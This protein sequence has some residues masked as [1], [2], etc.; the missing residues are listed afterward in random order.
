ME[1]NPLSNKK[2]Q[3]FLA[4]GSNLGD[5]Q[6]ALHQAVEL[7]GQRVGTVIQK[8]SIIETPAWGL[9]NLPDY[10]N[11]VLKVNTSLWPL[12]L[13]KTTLEIENELGRE[14]IQ[15][16][17]SRIIDIDILYFNDWHFTTPGLIIPHPFIAQ[18]EFVLKPLCEIAPEFSHPI[19][20][21]SN[22]SLMKA[23]H[24]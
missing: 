2:H 11:Q 20:R 24:L 12:D 10:L 13:I 16:W 15:K 23:L 7:I 3:V 1:Q 4:L 14:R 22:Y 5:R 21:R 19:L 9:T 8:S 18:R 6:S 17:G